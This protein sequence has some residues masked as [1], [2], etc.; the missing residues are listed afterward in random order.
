MTTPF[1]VG[2]EIGDHVPWTE[3]DELLIVDGS[4]SQV[5]RQPL[6]SGRT[7]DTLRIISFR[8]YEKGRRYTVKVRFGDH[9]YIVYQALDIYDAVTR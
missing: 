5:L 4:G 3:A 6:S 7:E 2:V 8:D 9:A 1:E